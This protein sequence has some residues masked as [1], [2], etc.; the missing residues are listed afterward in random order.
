MDIFA[1][2]FNVVKLSDLENYIQELYGFDPHIRDRA[3][4]ASNELC[5]F[6][7]DG[8]LTEWETDVWNGIWRRPNAGPCLNKLC[9]DHHIPE[10]TYLVEMYS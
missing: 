7:I 3:D 6:E 5:N 8:N 1:K 9:K 10:G 4:W 2:E